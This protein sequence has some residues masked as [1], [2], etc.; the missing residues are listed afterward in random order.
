MGF[1]RTEGYGTDLT[2]SG[3]GPLVGSCEYGYELWGG[4]ALSTSTKTIR[5]SRMSPLHSV[6]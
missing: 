6:N 3:Y 5:F 1:N 4:G 2:S